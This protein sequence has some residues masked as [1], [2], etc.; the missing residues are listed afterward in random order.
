M[1]RMRNRYRQSIGGIGAGD[2]HAGKQPRDH[3]MDLRLFRAAGPDHGLLDEGRGIFA[4]LDPGAGGAH[5][6]HAAGL[7]ELQRRLRVLV[8]EHFLD[9]GGGG[10]VVSNQRIELVGEGRKPARQRRVGIR[11]DLSVGDV[12]QPIAFSLDQAPAGRAEPRIEAEDFQASFSSSSSGT[13]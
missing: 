3:R 1:M 13:S 8:D 2:L 12:R 4:D 10:R 6:R 5:Q 11:L 7:P 9:R